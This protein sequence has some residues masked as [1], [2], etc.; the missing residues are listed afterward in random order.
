MYVKIMGINNDLHEFIV[1]PPDVRYSGG[2]RWRAITMICVRHQ[3]D[4]QWLK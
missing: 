4:D 3:G 2:T 1:Q